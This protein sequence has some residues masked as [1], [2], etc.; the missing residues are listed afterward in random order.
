LERTG[1]STKELSC[2]EVDH[3]R[4]FDMIETAHRLRSN[5]RRFLARWNGKV[6]AATGLRFYSG[7]M[8]DYAN[9]CSLD[10][11]LQLHPNDLL[12]WK[13][14]QWACENGFTKYCCGSADSFFRR[15]GGNDATDM[16][17]PPRPDVSAPL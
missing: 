7:G 11:F 17:L 5:H 4:T 9:N 16:L 10:E 2:A 14:I 6:I 12:A 15:L 8:V 3:S 1:F 13:T